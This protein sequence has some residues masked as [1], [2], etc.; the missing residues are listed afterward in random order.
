MSTVISNVFNPPGGNPFVG[1]VPGNVDFTLNTALTSALPN[2]I[3]NT[4]QFSIDA[5]GV[6]M[7]VSTAAEEGNRVC[8]VVD[9]IST[10][11]NDCGCCDQFTVC[12][13]PLPTCDETLSPATIAA[14]CP[15]TISWGTIAGL[16][17]NVGPNFAVTTGATTVSGTVD[18]NTIV[19]QIIITPDKND[20]GQSRTLTVCIDDLDEP[21][22]PPVCATFTLNFDNF[23]A[24]FSAADF[25]AN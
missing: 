12:L 2:G 24:G 21:G 7:Y 20:A 10:D 1:Y 17:S 15:T 8:A 4:G 6:L 13:T 18:N 25:D 23:C 19:G 5:N 22:C 9:I 16:A 14:S 11:P 3:A